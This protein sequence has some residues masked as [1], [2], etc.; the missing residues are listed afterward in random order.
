MRSFV[1]ACMRLVCGCRQ[2]P[3]LFNG[4]IVDRGD[5]GVECLLTLLLFK[6]VEPNSV[7]IN[8]GVIAV[9]A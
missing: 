5:F 3:Y 1:R 2:N 4:D 6:L 9:R 8:R 7:H